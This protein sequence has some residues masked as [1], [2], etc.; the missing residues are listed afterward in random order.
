[1][2]LAFSLVRSLFEPD[3]FLKHVRPELYRMHGNDPENVH[4][5]VLGLLNKHRR[6]IKLLGPF[7][8]AP[9]ELKIRLNNQEIVPFGTAAGMDKNCQVLQELSYF[10]GFLVPGTVVVPERDGNKRPRVASVETDL[11]TYNAQG[12]PSKGL[13]Y[14]FGNLIEHENALG[15]KVPIIASICGLPVSEKDAV[16]VAMLEMERLL[17]TLS[18]YVFGF[19]WNPFSPN[20]SALSRLRTPEIFRQT[21]RLMKR[22]APDKLLL[23]KMGPY[24]D[25]ADERRQFLSLV[26]AFLD[27][28]GHGISAVNT[29][30][31]PREQIPVR[32]WGYPSGGR[33]GR[34][35]QPYRMRAVKDTREAFPYAVIA[36]AGGIYG[37]DD[38]YGT[39]KAGAT[40]LQGY[41]PYT[42]YGL[43]LVRQIEKEVAERLRLEGYQNLDQL[44]AEA[45]K[46]A[47][48]SV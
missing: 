23:V 47:R 48:L 11:D 35:L 6:A 34:F 19:E 5:A 41:T 46:Y 26:D 38:A 14:C 40:L 17:T 8:G 1:M 29:R 31:F 18:S 20:T 44:K 33:S 45:R 12:F 24:E 21:A 42:Y 37:G 43:G 3:Y 10:F 16:E 39:F 2:G 27:G 36:G 15:K 30:M 9:E 28:G 25:D 13:D 22:Y 4:E 7:S 32:D